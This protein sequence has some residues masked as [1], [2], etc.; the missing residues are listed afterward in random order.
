MLANL[1]ASLT[2]VLRQLEV[3][4]QN[5][6]AQIMAVH[7]ALRTLANT[8]RATRVSSTRAK[9]KRHRMSAANRKAVSRR[10]KAYWAKRRAASAKGK[11][12]GTQKA[13]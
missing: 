12:R 13:G 10:M 11:V 7:A 8:H 2:K 9:G 5:V 3:E 4:K 6:D 1:T